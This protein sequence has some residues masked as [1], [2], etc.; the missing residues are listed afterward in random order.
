MTPERWRQVSRVFQSTLEQSP[1]RRAAFLA[2][3]CRGDSDLRRE[4]ES[5]LARE[6]SPVLVDRPVDAAGG[7]GHVGRRVGV[8]EMLTLVLAHARVAKTAD[9]GM[10]A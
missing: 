6:Q 1:A 5:L 4:V 8:L 7:H 2:D 10:L 3:A 9:V